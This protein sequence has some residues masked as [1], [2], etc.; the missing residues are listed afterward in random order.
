MIKISSINPFPIALLIIRVTGHTVQIRFFH[1]KAI[2]LLHGSRPDGCGPAGA[3][4]CFEARS[5]P[6]AQIEKRPIIF[7]P[8]NNLKSSVNLMRM[9]LVLWDARQNPQVHIKKNSQEHRAH[10][11]STQKGQ[12][13][14]LNNQS[15]NWELNVRT[16]APYYFELA[17]N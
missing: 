6:H 9:F 8:K 2:H 10:A 17:E 7:T 15:Q 13:L 3:D 14:D 11:N 4:I 16:A 1:F 5:T 12:R